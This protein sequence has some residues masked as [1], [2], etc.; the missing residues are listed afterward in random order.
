MTV[1]IL[2][3]SLRSRI[4]QNGAIFT[5]KSAE[6]ENPITKTRKIKTATLLQKVV[7]FSNESRK[8]GQTEPKLR[9]LG[10]NP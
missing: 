7:A 2:Q 3:K 4:Y 5:D 9:R 8:R 6:M 1:R 10:E